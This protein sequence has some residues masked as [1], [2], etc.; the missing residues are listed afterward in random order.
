MLD[1][2]LKKL[3]SSYIE[4]KTAL[5]QKLSELHT[6]EKENSEL[7]HSMQKNEDCSDYEVF[8]P[9]S[10]HSRDEDEIQK[11]QENESLFQSELD[12]LNTKYA[13]CEENL[14][15]LQK[16]I[17]EELTP[18]A[19]SEDVRENL[20]EEEDELSD[21]EISF[22]ESQSLNISEISNRIE[23]ALRRTELCYEIV[24]M[25]SFRCKLELKN[26]SEILRQVLSEL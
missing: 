3:Q 11:L 4:E 17:E 6:R 19:I 8:S 18:V 1:T 20:R 25:D 14:N 15:E 16:I 12:E 7:L 21:T 23:D 9:R 24:Q 5:E 10:F 13:Q 26:I 2:Y 22:D